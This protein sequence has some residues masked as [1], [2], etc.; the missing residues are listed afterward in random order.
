MSSLFEKWENIAYKIETQEE[1]DRFW[2]DYLP[3]E[4]K[5]YEYI[6]DS[7]DKKIEFTIKELANKFN[8]DEV[9]AVGFLDG[10]NSSLNEEL[11]MDKLNEDSH[12]CLKINFNKL[13]YNMLDAKAQWLYELSGWNNILSEDVRKDIKKEYNR[14]KTYVNENKI[15]R[16]DS[17]SCGSGKKYKKCCGK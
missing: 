12:L 15:G 9:T 5:F 11:E 3:K 6:L 4:T 17:C 16:N 7:Y 14:A 10:I 1:Y 8:V 13:Y 2:G